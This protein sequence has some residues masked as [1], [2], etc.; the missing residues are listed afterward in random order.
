MMYPHSPGYDLGFNLEA[1]AHIKKAV[2]MPVM[3]VGNI[4][5]AIAESALSNNKADFICF[6]RGM[7]ADADLANK[8]A[9]RAEGIRPCLNCCTCLSPRPRKCAVNP[10]IIEGRI[11]L[12]PA[13]KPRR[14]LVVGGGPSGMEA[15]RTAALR[16]HYVT[17]YE[18]DRRLGG[19]IQLASVLREED[20]E[21]IKYQIAEL[22]R[23][24]VKVE[25]GR[26]ADLETIGKL[27][28]DVIVLATGATSMLPDIP[29]KDGE[30]VLRAS[31]I[32]SMIGGH[33]PRK[34]NDRG[35][36]WRRRVWF[37]GA[38]VMRY[39]GPAAT[40][41]LLRLWAPFGKR[42]VIVGL[43]LPGV[44]LADFMVQHGTHVT[45]VGTRD[46]LYP[47]QPMPVFKLF[48]EQRL[49]LNGI[50]KMEAEKYEWVT[51]KGLTIID[52]QGRLRSI[53]GDTVI[54]VED[55]CPN[56]RLA[57]KL[58]SIG[59]EV[60]EIGDCVEPVGILEAIHGGSKVGRII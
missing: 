51:G 28:P 25:T 55:Y 53:A 17:L 32:Q 21:L 56:N 40:R 19:Q 39:L 57:A 37:L 41:W 10:A 49:L 26:T 43:G 46:V 11:E 15:A 54:F 29:G 9:N 22:K 35:A 6:G 34:G 3:A 5:P 12:E 2:K 48:L 23:I 27:A 44:E 20:M 16:G 38:M 13:K 18:K 8:A 58:A 14:V 50:V 59:Y 24:G 31:D 47:A 45:L 36:S 1:A 52:K 30:N 4:T 7:I 42:V 60:Y 33:M